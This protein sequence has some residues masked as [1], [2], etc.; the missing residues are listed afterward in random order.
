MMEEQPSRCFG[1][2]FGYHG[3]LVKA[4]STEIKSNK[5]RGLIPKLLGD[6]IGD[7]APN[8][9]QSIIDTPTMRNLG[10]IL[11]PSLLLETQVTAVANSAFPPSS[12]GQATGPLLFFS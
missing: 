5:D 1:Q 11:D 12:T 8:P 10:V 3:C 2:G 9:W 4:E 6:G 7:S